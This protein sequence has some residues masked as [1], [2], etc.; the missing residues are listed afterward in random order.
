[1]ASTSEA[2]KSDES[3]VPGATDAAAFA[4][5][6]TAFGEELK[7]VLNAYV[8]DCD[9]ASE[10]LREAT[11][12]AYWQESARLALHLGHAAAD[13][14]FRSIAKAA[15]AFADAVYQDAS[16]HQLRNGAQTLVF[17]YERQR[18]ALEARYPEFV[19]SETASVA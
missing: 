8:T 15:R 1:M 10:Q 11:A 5:L 13:L 19:A 16:A 6:E 9:A 3:G 4:A 2:L 12:C 18:L 7:G 14:G 17:E